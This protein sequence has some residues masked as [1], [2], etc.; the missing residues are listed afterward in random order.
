MGPNR[1]NRAG[2]ARSATPGRRASDA[3]NPQARFAHPKAGRILPPAASTGYQI[4][5]DCEAPELVV[6]Y[7]PPS[8]SV[9]LA[10]G[11]EVICHTHCFAEAEGPRHAYR[12]M[13]ARCEPA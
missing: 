5:L 13:R 6:T 2:A 4:T 11:G 10:D 8:F 1:L 7:E 3:T 9:I 12:A